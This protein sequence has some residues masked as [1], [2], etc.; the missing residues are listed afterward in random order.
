ME[1]QY[2]G[3]RYVPIF[4]ENPNTGDST[5]LSGVA[6]EVLTI[7]TFAGNSYTSKKPVPAG[8]GAPN[9]NP[10]YWVSTGNYNAQIDEVRQEVATVRDDLETLEETADTN[11]SRIFDK[12][13]IFIADSYGNY[14]NENNRNMIAEACYLLGI[15]DY[16]DFHR[17]SAGFHRTGELNFLRVL[18]DNDSVITDKTVITDIFVLG[19]ANDQLTDASET[20]IT[21]GMASFSAYVKANYPNATTHVGFVSKSF[22]IS[23]YAH[24]MRAL[25]IY[26]QC[27]KY[28]MEYLTGSE[29]IMQYNKLFR[30]DMTHPTT[31]AVN[32]IANYLTQLI[33]SHKCSV[34]YDLITNP[35]SIDNTS[36]SANIRT[37]DSYEYFNDGKCGIRGSNAA[38][39]VRIGCSIPSMSAGEYS[40]SGLALTDFFTPPFIANSNVHSTMAQITYSGQEIM[41]P[42]LLSMKNEYDSNNSCKL[43]LFLYPTSAL[44]NVTNIDVTGDWILDI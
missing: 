31:E 25:A 16:Y 34:A 43:N 33:I 9:A 8:I 26:K 20:A 23:E 32:H 15:T 13:Y 36:I 14:A 24:Y 35:F 17:G 38:R 2:I 4:F 1:R 18:S 5:W 19:G 11:F 44:T 30:T 21:S 27:G 28:G 37:S 10:E 12:K 22:I 7:V 3:A 6:Y 29:M 41:V 42:A 40:V 39:I